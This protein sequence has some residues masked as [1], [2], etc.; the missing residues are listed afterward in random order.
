[1][2]ESGR[3][4]SERELRDELEAVANRTRDAAFLR[5]SRDEPTHSV[6]NDDEPWSAA[7]VLAEMMAGTYSRGACVKV[8]GYKLYNSTVECGM[9]NV[10]TVH[11]PDGGRAIDALNL[12]QFCTAS[13]VESYI[14][15]LAER[16]ERTSSESPFG[17]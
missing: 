2:S 10:W 11:T 13:E 17:E 12:D 7:D 16:D 1:M 3:I 6:P 14:L 4:T 5:D 15:E 9:P 8:F